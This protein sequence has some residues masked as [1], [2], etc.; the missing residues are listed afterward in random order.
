MYVLSQ[1]VTLDCGAFVTSCIVFFKKC[2]LS[3]VLWKFLQKS[4]DLLLNCDHTDT[5]SIGEQLRPLVC[6]CDPALILIQSERREIILHSKHKEMFTLIRLPV[7][8]LLLSGGLV[9]L[10]S[11]TCPS[12]LW[13]V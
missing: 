5:V 3:H 4:F 11:L 12:V 13:T 10:L 7:I 6:L 1:L 9:T 2:C 8:F